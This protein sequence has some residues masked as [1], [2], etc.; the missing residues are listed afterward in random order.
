MKTALNIIIAFLILFIWSEFEKNSMIEKF[1]YSNSILASIG[2]IFTIILR[3][4]HKKFVE[5][6]I[7]AS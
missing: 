4:N 2:L 7:T 1:D 6:L 3:I 5:F